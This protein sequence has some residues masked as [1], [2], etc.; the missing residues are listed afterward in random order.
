MHKINW[1]GVISTVAKVRVKSKI[2]WNLSPLSISCNIKN[3]LKS[4]VVF[5]QKKLMKISTMYRSI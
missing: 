3:L 1:T 5:L 2:Y 4:R